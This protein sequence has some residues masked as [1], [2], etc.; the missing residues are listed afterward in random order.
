MSK[1]VIKQKTKLQS[2]KS[3]AYLDLAS[4]VF[5]FSTCSCLME[6]NGEITN[7]TRLLP[8]FKNLFTAAPNN[9][10]TNDFPKPV[11]QIISVS[12]F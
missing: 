2:S 3:K 10:Y 6:I 12:R 1:H 11:G 7:V 8:S 9:W 4:T 5:I